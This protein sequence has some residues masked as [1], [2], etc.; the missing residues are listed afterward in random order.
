MVSFSALQSRASHCV[1]CIQSEFNPFDIA[2]HI[3]MQ[4]LNAVSSLSKAIERINDIH[5]R[6]HAVML[7]HNRAILDGAR[8]MF[9][10]E[11]GFKG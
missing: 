3:D 2:D 10:A 7:Q 6:N 11:L 9:G 4:P 8:A 1:H 5:L